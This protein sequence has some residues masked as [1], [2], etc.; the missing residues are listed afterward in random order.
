METILTK[1]VRVFRGKETILNILSEYGKSN[2][3]IKTF[4]QNNNLASA[5]FHNWQ[6]KYSNAVAKP[7]VQPGFATLQVNPS[8][9]VADPALFAAVKGIK[10]YQPVPAAYLKELLS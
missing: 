1:K 3:S 4:C 8:G 7:D 5:T 10:I 9:P 2:L 6:K